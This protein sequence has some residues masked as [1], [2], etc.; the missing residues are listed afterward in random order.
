[1]VRFG[2]LASDCGR[3]YSLLPGAACLPGLE[4]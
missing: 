3:L 1:M 2:L 4:N